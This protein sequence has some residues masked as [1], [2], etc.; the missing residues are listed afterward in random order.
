MGNIPP[1]IR[2]IVVG[3]GVRVA[4]KGFIVFVRFLEEYVRIKMEWGKVKVAQAYQAVAD[5][6][7]DSRVAVKS[8]L[9]G[10]LR[11][12]YKRTKFKFLFNYFGIEPEDYSVVPTLGEVADLVTLIQEDRIKYLRDH[13]TSL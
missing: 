5:E 10:A 1:D 4:N 11:H 7:N 12:A 3:M 8:L 6:F 13:P 2:G 9:E